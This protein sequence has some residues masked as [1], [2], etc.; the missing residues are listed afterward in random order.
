MKL[1]IKQAAYLSRIITLI[2]IL[3]SYKSVSQTAANH[4][5]IND[6]K[7]TEN[8]KP[9]VGSLV[10]RNIKIQPIFNQVI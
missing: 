9:F 8:Q 7:R 3:T 2:V 6:L 10:K 5:S 4:Q 1:L